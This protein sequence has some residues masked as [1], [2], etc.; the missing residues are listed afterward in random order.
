MRRHCGGGRL[1]KEGRWNGFAA[2]GN[3]S[4]HETSIIDS[5]AKLNGVDYCLR[6]EGIMCFGG[7]LR[8]V[9]K[10]DSFDDFELEL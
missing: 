5:V 4:Q 9:P 3:H 8:E 1:T 2:S 10:T 7:V 6:Y